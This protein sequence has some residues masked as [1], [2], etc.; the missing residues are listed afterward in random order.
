MTDCNHALAEK[1]TTCADGACPLCLEAA[2]EQLRQDVK[3]LLK[4]IPGWAAHVPKGPMCPT[5]Y[6]TLSEEGD[7]KVK[8]QVDEIKARAGNLSG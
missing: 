6:G 1:E 5:F 3:F 4:F 7:L 8:A 2:N